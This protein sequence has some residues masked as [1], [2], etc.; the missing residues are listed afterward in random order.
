MRRYLCLLVLEFV[1]LAELGQTCQFTDIEEVE[2]TSGLAYMIMLHIRKCLGHAP[3]NILRNGDAICSSVQVGVL[4]TVALVWKDRSGL[5]TELDL[6]VHTRTYVLTLT[7]QGNP[8][9]SSG[10]E[11]SLFV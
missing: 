1:S 4:H 7:L 3:T 5:G 10:S 9:S 11:R 6:Y 2:N 8:T